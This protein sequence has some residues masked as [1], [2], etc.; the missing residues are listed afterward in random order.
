M[1]SINA[2]GMLVDP[3]VIARRFPSIE[4][5]AL[6]KVQAILIHQ[7]DSPT[8]ESAFHAYTQQA[9]GAH[10]LI[11]KDGQ[12]YQT[13]SIHK[14][15]YHVGRRIRSK[16]LSLNL[17]GCKTPAMMQALTRSGVAQYSAIDQI[18]RQKAYP[19]R[20]PVN[21]DSVGIE[22]VGRHIDDKTYEA[23]TATQDASLQW[24]VGELFRHLKLSGQDVYKHPE[25]SYKNPGEAASARWP[26]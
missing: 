17:A 13:A 18:E 11:G 5:G 7:T 22:L 3:L 10:F 12:I 26:Q 4:H 19:D 15:C 14:L 20:Y 24:L 23:L 2:D 1:S 16:C 25:V 6:K 8:V 21:S 9:T